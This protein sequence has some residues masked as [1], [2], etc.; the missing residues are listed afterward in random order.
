MQRSPVDVLFSLSRQARMVSACERPTESAFLVTYP[1]VEL[2]LHKLLT[3]TQGL[4]TSKPAGLTFPSLML[5]AAPFRSLPRA[6]TWIP[7]V[8]RAVHHDCVENGIFCLGYNVPFIPGYT[9]R[10]NAQTPAVSGTVVM[11]PCTRSVSETVGRVR[12]VGRGLG[13]PSPSAQ[14]GPS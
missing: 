12:A 2:L 14:Q 6:L 11:R 13:R 1:R 7:F 3:R 10:G 5:N 4:A 8:K 9:C